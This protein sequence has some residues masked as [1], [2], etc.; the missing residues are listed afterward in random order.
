MRRL[1]IEIQN[2]LGY[3]FLSVFAAYI[4]SFF[5][6]LVRFGYARFTWLWQYFPEIIFTCGFLYLFLFFLL[7]HT[8]FFPEHERKNK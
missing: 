8:S 2:T 3:I 6:E 1:L 7:H 5:A 4:L